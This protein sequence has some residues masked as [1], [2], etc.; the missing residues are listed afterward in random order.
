M[1]PATN[2]RNAQAFWEA[3]YLAAS[4]TEH[5]PLTMISPTEASRIRAF[6]G[7]LAA[8]WALLT[9][10]DRF[11]TPEERV[12]FEEWRQAQDAGNEG[13]AGA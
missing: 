12:Q 1:T 5:N 11:G 10:L 2:N 3:A 9:W 6:N 8:N 7:E 13:E 4:S